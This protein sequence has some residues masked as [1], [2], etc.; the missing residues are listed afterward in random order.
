MSKVDN[1]D[2]YMKEIF[3]DIDEANEVRL[4]QQEQ[5]ILDNMTLRA[6]NKELLSENTL[7]WQ[8]IDGIKR[9][10]NKV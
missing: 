4:R 5:L 6:K 10:V 8:A 7:L 1:N 9:E 2:A 3:D